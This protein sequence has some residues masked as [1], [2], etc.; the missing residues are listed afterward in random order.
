[1]RSRK[2]AADSEEELEIEGPQCLHVRNSTPHHKGSTFQG[3]PA[4]PFAALISCIHAA[5]QPLGPDMRICIQYISTW[6]YDVAEQDV[7]KMSGAAKFK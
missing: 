6:E 2:Y 7:N 1:M 3:Q 4:R 5:L